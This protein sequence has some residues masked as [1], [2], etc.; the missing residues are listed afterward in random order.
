MIKQIVHK[1]GIDRAIGY[2][3][4]SRLVQAGGG[5]LLIF[6]ISL[7]MSKEEQGY[8]FTFG[9]ILA[10]QI[11]LELGLNTVIT[12]YVAHE[13]VHIQWSPVSGL[14]G[15]PEHVS[16]LSSLL[17]FCLRVF[18]VMAIILFIV[19]QVAGDQF[20]GRF[21]SS[22]VN[23]QTAWHAVVLFTSLMVIV[24]PFLAFLEGLGRVQEVA[25]IRFAQQVVNLAA[26]SLTLF[27]KGGLLAA[28]AGAMLSFIVLAG[29]LL[30]RDNRTIL[31]SIFK[32]LSVWK[33]SYSKEIFPYQYKIALSWISG[34]FI[35]Q[36]FNPVI[37]AVD[38]AVA[39]G[40]MGMTL[41]ALN[42]IS[43]LSMSWINTKVPL[44]SS[45]IARKE[46]HELDSIFNVTLRQL[47]FVNL[48]LL[49]ILTFFITGI[50]FLNLPLADR[51]IDLLPLIMMSLTV[52][53]NQ[54]I[55]SWATYLRCHKEEPYLINS[56]VG[57][58][59]CAASTFILGNRFGLMGVVTGYTALTVLLGLPWSYI[60][61]RQ[62]RA[63]WHVDH[64]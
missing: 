37:F 19:L 52:L 51:F 3:V 24:N 48:G 17:R 26:I 64:K 31:N 7:F 47:I 42:G 4:L 57:G 21:S 43:A 15:S 23:W 54:L 29:G 5:L 2:T 25:K 46:Y 8:Y 12:Q 36:L 32:G 33:M 28:G 16:R 39:A 55:F 14:S 45:L 59:L 20:F 1:L 10:I 38:G 27:L 22:D 50:T 11:F 18:S 44:F 53:A 41:A 40:Q 13:A 60:V 9:S 56:I 62:K 49:G 6:L 61:F 58:V 30:Q 35:F 34:Y 63:Q